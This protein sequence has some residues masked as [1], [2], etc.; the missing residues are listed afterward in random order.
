MF[1][2]LRSI[3]AALAG[4]RRFEAGMADELRFHLEQYA[5]ELTR[6]GVPAE[7]AARRA[8]LEFGSLDNVKDDCREA[9]GLRLF[10]DLGRDLRHAV[11]LLVRTP[12]FTVS[13]AATIAL[14]L[15]ANLAIFAF[16]DAIL[17]RPLPFPHSDRLVRVYNTYPKAGVTDD[18]AS[19]TNY[20]ERR[21][22]SRRCRRWRS[23][24]RPAPSSARPAPRNGWT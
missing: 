20:Y 15:A 8:R 10:D 21:D 24:A 9:R 1:Q 16:V 14:C 5:E 13:A 23:T 2:R 4:R 7:E 17:L 11:R 3:L 6:A 12:A 18:G 19:V 22:G